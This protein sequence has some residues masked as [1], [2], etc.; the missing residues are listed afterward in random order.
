MPSPPDRPQRPVLLLVFFLLLHVLNQV[1][2]NLIASFGPEIVR[3][4]GL[5]R[6]EFGIVTGIAFT[7]A[8]AVTA[9]AAGV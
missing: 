8:Y 4:L 1:D 9:L 6:T 3:D 7:I 2:R 5:S